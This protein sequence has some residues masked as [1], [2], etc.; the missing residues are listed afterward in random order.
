MGV[1]KREQELVHITFGQTE[2]K[3]VL[4]QFL[5][6]GLVCI[7]VF[8]ILLYIGDGDFVCMCY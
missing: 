6:A 4:N 3:Y 5:Y 7:P 1:L 8:S 2:R